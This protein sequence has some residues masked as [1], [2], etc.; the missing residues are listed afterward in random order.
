MLSIRDIDNSKHPMFVSRDRIERAATENQW[1]NG[2]IKAIEVCRRPSINSRRLEFI[3]SAKSYRDLLN[4][5]LV[6][7]WPE[8]A[9]FLDLD[10]DS[11]QVTENQTDSQAG[12]EP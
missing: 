11:M 2:K 9:P 1:M 10:S 7:N 12:L 8:T 6:E 5:A 3:H 4:E